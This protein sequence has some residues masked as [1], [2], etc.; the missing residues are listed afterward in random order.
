[1]RVSFLVLALTL[2]CDPKI[3]ATVK[4]DSRC[5]FVQEGSVGGHLDSKGKCLC[6]VPEETIVFTTVLPMKDSYHST[7]DPRPE[8]KYEDE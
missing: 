1:M 5:P 8:R 2:A 4:C 6:D 7:Y 3:I